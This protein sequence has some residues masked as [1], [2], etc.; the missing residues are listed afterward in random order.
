M[1]SFA[2]RAV[3]ADTLT[4]LPEC[5]VVSVDLACTPSRLFEIFADPDSWP[6]W[7]PGIRKV[8]WT[9]PPPHGEGATRTVTLLG[10]AQIEEQF[11]VWEP[12]RRLSFYVSECNQPIWHAFAETYAVVPVGDD[13][14]RLTWTVAYE[15]RAGAFA[16]MHPWIRPVMRVTLRT[17]MAFLKRYVARHARATAGVAASAA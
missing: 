15:P 4:E 1:P 2:C 10:G 3:D 13:A 14:C 5:H 6:S 16:R 8:E 9:T 17:F 12:G 11:T 7:A